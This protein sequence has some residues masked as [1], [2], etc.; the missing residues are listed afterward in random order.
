MQVRADPPTCPILAALA[1]AGVLLALVACAPRPA[2]EEDPFVVADLFAT[3]GKA[4]ATIEL[5]A[6]PEPTA[7]IPNMPSPTPAPT[8]PLPTAIV[9]LQP[10]M[11]LGAPGPTPTLPQPALPPTPT[12]RP[13]CPAPPA[14]FVGAWAAS[15]EASLRLGCPVRGPQAVGGVFQ[16]YEHGAMFWRQADG[17]IFVISERAIQQGQPTDTWWRFGDTFQEGEEGSGS[18]FEPPEGLIEPVR[19][20]GK[21]WRGNAFVRDA[22]GWATTPE[23]GFESQWLEFERGWMLTGPDNNPVYTLIPLDAP[24]HST[25]VHFGRFPR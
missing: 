19:G 6:T 15:G 16:F 24:P 20:F 21:V 8:R 23:M 1:L 22:L 18:G 25:G 3:P 10:T 5:T 13:D 4:L 9:L 12:P 7:T 11:P 14:P 17:S 2:A